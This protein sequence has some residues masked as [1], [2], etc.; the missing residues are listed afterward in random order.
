MIN[1]L[2]TIIVPI[3][4][5]E[6]YLEQCLYSL[7]NQS[8]KS[9]DIICI[10][11]GSN[12]ESYE[13]LKRFSVIDQRI[14]V[15]SKNNEGVSA[16]RNIALSQAKGEFI[17][18]VDADDW[19]E[20]NT[21]EL[22]IQKMI[23]F[24]SD[25]VIWSYCSERNNKSV[26]K[27]IFDKD[28]VFSDIDIKRRIHRRFIG[29]INDELA[30]PELADSLCPVWGKLYR[31]ILIKDIQFVDLKIIGTYE[32][33]LFNLNAFGKV[34]KAVY[35]DLPL[36]HYRRNNDCSQTNKFRERFLGF[37]A[38]CLCTRFV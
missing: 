15:I 16:S 4:N 24:S 13:I 30:H 8:Y 34:K 17:M 35:I 33:G 22:A 23:A 25:V 7:I 38:L 26:T 2:V 18:F 19:L 1:G 37:Q 12:D 31:S 9:L 14:N 5:A 32:D 36:Y 6:A 3:Y 29:L 28:Y 21:V 11:D 27:H 20:A 10:N